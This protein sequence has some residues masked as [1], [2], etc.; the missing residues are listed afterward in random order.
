MTVTALAQTTRVTG[1]ALGVHSL[2]L[3]AMLRI[4]YGERGGDS[5]G[6]GEVAAESKY[7]ELAPT[8]VLGFGKI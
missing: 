4:N 1:S 8:T 7:D 2:T 3:A 5:K 6:E